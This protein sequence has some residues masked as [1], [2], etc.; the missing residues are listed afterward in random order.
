MI[1]QPLKDT[2]TED[3]SS[4]GFSA[5]CV[6]GSYIPLS[7]CQSPMVSPSL[8]I[9]TP[10]GYKILLKSCLLACELSRSNFSINLRQAS[11]PKDLS[12]FVT[13]TNASL[14]TLHNEIKVTHSCV[15]ICGAA[16]ETEHRSGEWTSGQCRLVFA[17]SLA[18]LLL[19]GT[20]LQT[21]T[22][23]LSSQLEESFTFPQ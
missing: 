1:N 22:L 11:I 23:N 6:R 19:S 8:P 10:L 20:V 9:A 18:W 4:S 5:F 2:S 17:P 14:P 3:W 13:T 16:G 7:S 15:F 12:L 21:M